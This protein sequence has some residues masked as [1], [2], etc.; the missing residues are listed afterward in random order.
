MDHSVVGLNKLY[1]SFPIAP[2]TQPRNL[3]TWYNTHEHPFK[4]KPKWCDAQNLLFPTSPFGFLSTTLNHNIMKW[5]NTSFHTLP[6]V[7]THNN[8]VIDPWQII[9][10]S[11]NIPTFNQC[12][13]SFFNVHHFF[14]TIA[15]ILL[16]ALFRNI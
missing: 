15:M 2:N 4:K 5:W 7:T 14:T 8:L 12:R 6:I 9:N 3:I 10:T 1:P 13:S 16:W 11:P